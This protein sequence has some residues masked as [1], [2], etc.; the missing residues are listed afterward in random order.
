MDAVASLFLLFPFLPEKRLQKVKHPTLPASRL[1]VLEGVHWPLIFFDKKAHETQKKSEALVAYRPPKP[2]KQSQ[3]PMGSTHR[4]HYF[5]Q[6]S[7]ITDFH[8]FKIFI[9]VLLF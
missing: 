9:L 6:S 2:P 3:D 4:H 5:D 7:F 8:A 1:A